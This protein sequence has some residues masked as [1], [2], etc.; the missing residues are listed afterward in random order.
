[1]NKPNLNSGSKD[2]FEFKSKYLEGSVCGSEE[3]FYPDYSPNLN[4]YEN[5]YSHLSQPNIQLCGDS[6]AK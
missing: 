3:E 2:N 4:L 5:I 1:M 6:Q